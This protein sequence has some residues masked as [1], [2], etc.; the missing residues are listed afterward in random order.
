MHI[1]NFLLDMTKN[2]HLEESQVGTKDG[3]GTKHS[4]TGSV[5]TW[6]GQLSTEIP[7][8][9]SNTVSNME[10][11]WVSHKSLDTNLGNNWQGSESGGDKG[12][13][14]WEGTGQRRDGVTKGQGVETTSHGNTSDSV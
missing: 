14:Q 9:M 12:R 4:V 8:Q 10:D 5:D 11:E 7:N 13:V 1:Y 2:I 3:G 6:D